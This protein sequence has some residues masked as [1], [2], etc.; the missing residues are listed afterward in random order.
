MSSLA[1]IKSNI[2][3]PRTY[4]MLSTQIEGK[5]SSKRDWYQF[6]E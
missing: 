1:Q 3:Q 6:L 5:L 2:G 4:D